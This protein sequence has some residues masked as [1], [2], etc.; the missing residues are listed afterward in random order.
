M[1]QCPP[2]HIIIMAKSI[3]RIVDTVLQSPDPDLMLKATKTFVTFN[4]IYTHDTIIDVELTEQYSK[5]VF[6]FCAQ[7]TY[8]TTDS[9]MQKKLHL[10]GL[11]AIQS[12]ANSDTFF[13]NPRSADYTE[14][15]IPAILSNLHEE[16]RLIA[17][18]PPLQKG[19]A[20]S[21]T[22]PMHI[23]LTDDLFTHPLQQQSALASLRALL[24]NTN[25]K[26]LRIALD[27]FW[28]YMDAKSE[29]RDDAHVAFLMDA[30]AAAI[31][32][33]HHY[34]LLG[35]LLERVKVSALAPLDRR[36]IVV[37]L[38]VL[39]SGGNSSGVAVVELLEAIVGQI[40]E[41]S[42]R[43]DAES[44]AL[45]GA[46]VEATGALA[47]HIAYPTQL[48]D[49]VGFIVNRLVKEDAAASK[50]LLL[51]SLLHVL[52]VRRA[53]VRQME[54]LAN[55]AEE[56]PHMRLDAAYF[57]VDG[58][59]GVAQAALLDSHGLRNKRT[60]VAFSVARIS[61][62]LLIPTLDLL[63]DSDQDVRIL[64]AMFLAATFALD[65]AQR[66][67][68]ENPADAELVANLYPK[69]YAYVFGAGNGPVDI[70]AV[71]CVVSVLVRRFGTR[72]DGVGR[73]LQFN[74]QLQSDVDSNT[75]ATQNTQA[76]VSSLLND[77]LAELATTYKIK[78]LT[79]QMALLSESLLPNTTR[80]DIFH[81]SVVAHVL[82][83]SSDSI[84]IAP[85]QFPA[86]A[87]TVTTEAP[88]QK[89]SVMPLLWQNSFLNTPS[90]RDTVESAF[91]TDAPPHAPP[92]LS[93]SN[94]FTPGS[95]PTP[96]SNDFLKP[97]PLV[98]S[99]ES[100][101]SAAPPEGAANDSLL[102]RADTPIKFEDLKD[103]ISLHSGA[104]VKLNGGGG[105]GSIRSTSASVKVGGKVD[106]KKLLSGISVTVANMNPKQFLD[107]GTS[108]GGR[109]QL[110]SRQKTG[111]A[112]VAHD[113]QASLEA[114]AGVRGSEFIIN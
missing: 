12:I 39:V 75:T 114:G 70:V 97:G 96:S 6:K 33:H 8:T 45:Q 18:S 46:L 65:V 26:T 94:N 89:S 64:E 103:A 107:P 54:S 11:R 29:W 63:L 42:A 84:I 38:T 50:K 49:L 20:P 43:K 79:A 76:A 83:K 109:V 4:S 32:P 88:I 19:E 55:L 17:T 93:K 5:L 72:A 24:A 66:E 1:A 105:E 22:A 9:I 100:S 25:S 68:Y 112:V 7:C 35:S 13:L 30:I 56:A 52:A 57:E 15:I 101:R 51:R 23:T 37:G 80:L 73:S 95:L 62:S 91:I 2:T 53:V 59:G 36:G 82:G 106:V 113:D 61:P 47:I 78:G 71:G 21:A 3:L 28:A 27:P 77:H 104:E 102:S 74:F 44:V 14:K 90:V 92:S 67:S 99:G 31:A 111:P 69:L 40:R 16:R 108:L 48:S 85:R 60:S 34:I 86:N 41:V 58:L 110:T 98:G 81:A 10:S 87:A